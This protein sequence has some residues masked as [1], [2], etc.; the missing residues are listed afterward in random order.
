[1]YIHVACIVKEVKSFRG[2]GGGGLSQLMVMARNRTCVQL[3]GL[4]ERCS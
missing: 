3:Y 2:G 4:E 1:M